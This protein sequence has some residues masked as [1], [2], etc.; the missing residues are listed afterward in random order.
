[1]VASLWRSAGGSLQGLQSV[2]DTD[3]IATDVT[4][5]VSIGIAGNTTFELAEASQ[6]FNFL[7]TGVTVTLSMNPSGFSFVSVPDPDEPQLNTVKAQSSVVELSAL[8]GTDLTPTVASLVINPQQIK[9]NASDGSGVTVKIE[10]N[11]TGI[12]LYSNASGGGENTINLSGD[13]MLFKAKRSAYTK[14]LTIRSLNNQDTF[15]GL[16]ITDNYATPPDPTARLDVDGGLRVRDLPSD[17]SHTK[18]VTVANDGTMGSAEMFNVK[19]KTADFAFDDVSDG[20]VYVLTTGPVN[21]TL[22]VD[23][24]SIG[25]SL[26]ILA[27]SGSMASFIDGTGVGVYGGVNTIA[28]GRG[29]NLTRLN[30]EGG[31]QIYHLTTMLTYLD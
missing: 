12:D 13:E 9:L 17:V 16:M 23:A 25:A 5:P 4:A 7:D 21:I 2:L 11:P 24:L 28:G 20:N 14:G 3:A 15:H 29:A 31:N 1:M 18:M 6:S 8:S 22:N 10:A 27:A 30:D 26:K 19:D